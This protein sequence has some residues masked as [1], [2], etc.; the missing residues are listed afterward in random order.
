MLYLLE[1]LNFLHQTQPQQINKFMR[2]ILVAEVQLIYSFVEAHFGRY[3][4]S[5]SD[6]IIFICHII[7]M[8]LSNGKLIF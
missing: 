4:V 1:Q 5:N 2:S 3:F 7:C 6:L 8:I